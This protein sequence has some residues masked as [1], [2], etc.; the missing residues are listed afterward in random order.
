MQSRRDERQK[1]PL[2]PQHA[3]HFRRKAR[4]SRE[5]PEKAGDDRKAPGWIEVGNGLKNSNGHTDQIATD[6]VG[7][8]RAAR[9][10]S[11]R[12]EP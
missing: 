12:I 9:D 2:L 10:D 5:C 4:E 7:C 8:E 3:H 11:A 6:Q 1:V